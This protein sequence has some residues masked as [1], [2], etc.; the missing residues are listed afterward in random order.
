MKQKGAFTIAVFLY[1]I[2]FETCI[3]IMSNPSLSAKSFGNWQASSYMTVA[4][5]KV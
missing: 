3:Y 4:G 5:D 1:C 2:N